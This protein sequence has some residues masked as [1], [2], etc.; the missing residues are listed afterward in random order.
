MSSILEKSEMFPDF[1]HKN[2]KE[3]FEKSNNPKDKLFLLDGGP[4][5]NSRKANNTMCKVRDKK[6]SIPAGGPDMNPIENLFTI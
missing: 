2:F 6:F 1:I 5:Q 3:A 4:S